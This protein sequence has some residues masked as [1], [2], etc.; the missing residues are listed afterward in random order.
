MFLFGVAI[1][2]RDV[3]LLAKGEFCLLA[4]PFCLA[5]LLICEQEMKETENLPT[6]ICQIKSCALQAIWKVN[7]SP[8]PQ[9]FILLFVSALSVYLRVCHLWGR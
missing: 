8:H 1:A 5:L 7:K 6:L 2:A 4:V 3:L 9:A